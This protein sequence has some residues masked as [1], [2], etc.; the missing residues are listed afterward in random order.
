MKDKIMKGKM[1]KRVL[2]FI[3]TLAMVFCLMPG[4]VEKVKAAEDVRT[5]GT[6]DELISALADDSIHR[7]IVSQTITLAH[8]TVL[9]GQGK[10]VQ[11]A[12]PYLE[13]SGATSDRLSFYNVF[14]V[15]SG[16]TVTIKNM[17]IFGGM[18][19]NAN[20]GGIVN[21][22]TLTLEN[23]TIARSN[24]GLCIA[25]RSSKAIL[26]NTNIVRNQ[27]SYGGGIFC[28][29]GTLVMD[30]CSL[31]EN[32]STASGGGAMEI[33]NSGTLYANNTVIANNSSS[34]IGG[35]INNYG[36]NVYLMNCQVT[37]NVTT[38]ARYGASAGAGL[39]INGGILKAVNSI[40]MDNYFIL[41]GTEE[42][43]ASDIGAYAGND[44]KL[45]NCI[46][47]K[48]QIGSGTI[49]TG[50]NNKEITEDSI[51][52]SYRNDGV[53]YGGS[54]AY[55]SAFKHPALRA[56]AGN[57]YAL[58]ANL[59]V[60]GNASSGGVDT[61]FDYSDLANVKMSYGPEASMTAMT[62]SQAGA[63][64]K[65]TTYYE[66]GERTS[67][68]I[69]ASAVSDDVFYT[70]KLGGVPSGG[71]VQGISI[72]G[73][74]YASGTS[75]TVSA[76]PNTGY[77]FTGWKKG[78]TIVSTDAKY[79]FSVTENLN[80]T[81]EFLAH[82]HSWNYKNGTGDD[83][84]KLYAYCSGASECPYAGSEEDVSKAVSLTL[85]ATS[86]IYS[87]TTVTYSDDGTDAKIK[88]DGKTAWTGAGLS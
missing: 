34:E 65:V 64:R 54:N 28:D 5:V 32:R 68:V 31:T 53:L 48:I 62:T 4:N 67:G 42:P 50:D 24:R 33:K 39:G 49:D 77:M 52:T 74:G 71:T 57:S 21:K 70:V 16:A 30:G 83:A 2:S 36:S 63:D 40:F 12:F 66:G 22:G 85:S 18:N 51:F 82:T 9:D 44:N 26:K 35:A 13:E 76:I 81:A 15:D 47:G 78:E 87:G 3:L 73:D 72:Y 38:A 43:V 1:T 41:R 25:G 58:Y 17:Q 79:T 80:L 60:S 56:K 69:G 8:G 86:Q 7:V 20:A 14:T 45:I 84:N 46:Y 29:G 6:L 27:C 37:G 11:V 19:G 55:T 10:T 61:Y 88:L 75:V 23:I 59:S